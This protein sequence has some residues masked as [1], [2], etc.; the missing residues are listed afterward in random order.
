MIDFVRDPNKFQI[1]WI[2]VPYS[3]FDGGL[4]VCLNVV[5]LASSASK[6]G[7]KDISILQINRN[8]ISVFLLIDHLICNWWM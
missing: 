4:F 5:K 8:K 6:W 2:R 7:T 1:L 3:D